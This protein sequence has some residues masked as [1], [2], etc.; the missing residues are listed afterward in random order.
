MLSQEDSKKKRE[1]LRN[2]LMQ[3]LMVKYGQH[4]KMMI[5]ALV[6]QFLIER[7]QIGPDDLAR[8]EKEVVIALDAR[9]VKINKSESK[10]AQAGSAAVGGGVNND[11]AGSSSSSSNAGPGSLSRGNSNENSASEL[12]PPP[13]GSEWSV[14]Q[15]YQLLMGEEATAN[16]KRIER[17]K[18]E[19]F[20]AA[21][22]SHIADSAK[23]KAQHE[24]AAD[25]QYFKHIRQDIKNYHEEE[26]KKFEK[27]HEKARLQLAAQNEQIAEKSRR[28][29]AELERQREFEEE[30]LA[31]ARRKIQEEK[32]K[33]DG[34]REVAMAN[35]AR[36]NAEN[37]ENQRLRAIEMEKNVAEDM[38][39][40]AE[41]AAKLD[42]EELEREQA[43]AKRM[44]KM[45]AFNEKFENEGAGNAIRQEQLRVERQLLADQAK[46]EAADK[47]AEDKKAYDKRVRLQRML[48]EN[49]KILER[50]AR[51]A[52]DLRIKDKNYADAAMADVAKFKQE[53][54][55]KIDRKN[56]NYSKYRL[57]LDAQMKSRKPQADPNS[58]EF[59]GREAELNK[60]LYEKAVH[61]P[62]VLKKYREVQTKGVQQVKVVVHK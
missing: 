9:K 6:E 26:R 48:A 45:A 2:V 13:P 41:Y 51:E 53:E 37:E 49:E 29:A 56:N 19:D 24:D 18:K 22:D 5:G 36:V 12:V 60:S 8:L 54:R 14:I 3:K 31:D 43:F 52:E 30:L 34:L 44:E 62:K 39:L 50:K 21:L 23:Y 47:A 35:A 40:Q 1:R 61:D 59:L 16:E 55:A 57:V 25:Q 20:R 4:N 11:N 33:M 15:A 42:R 28:R 7:D 38:R 46:K 27:I 58:A 32:N 10:L 17:K